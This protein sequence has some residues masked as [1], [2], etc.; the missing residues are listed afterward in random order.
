[1]N[2]D[3]YNELMAQQDSERV[4][5][6]IANLNELGSAETDP[7]C[8]ATILISVAN[9]FRRI[10]RFS[11]ARINI[12]KAMAL[13]GPSDQYYPRAAF[14]DALL[15]MHEHNWKIAL[16]KLGEILNK[17]RP[18]LEI[19]DHED[20]F[21]EVQRNRGIALAE[22]KQFSEALS[23]LK[24]Y[25]SEPYD[26][27]RTLYYIGACK[28]ELGDFDSARLAFEDILSLNCSSIFQ[29]YA[30]RYLGEIF[31]RNEKLPW[32][33]AEFEKSLAC[34]DRDKSSDVSVLTWLVNL[35]KSLNLEKDVAHY[36]EMLE[37]MRR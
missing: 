36:S 20:L 18:I 19:E 1:M 26:R 23:I 3:R 15:D 6:V 12:Q 34:P 2:W 31:F 17:F 14:Q 10:G 28:F 29:A 37:E 30:H 11:D 32:A 21:D 24:A 16:K 9:V 8:K 7:Q 25:R 35:S 33:K 27:E 22:V 4:E 13:L 5:E